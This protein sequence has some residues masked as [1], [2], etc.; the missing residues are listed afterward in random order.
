MLGV[1]PV[2]GLTRLRDE[3]SCWDHLEVPYSQNVARSITLLSYVHFARGELKESLRNIE[4]MAGFISRINVEVGGFEN[5]NSSY[6]GDYHKAI[7]LLQ[8]CIAGKEWICNHRKR[9]K[10]WSPKAMVG[11]C[12]RVR[13]GVSLEFDRE[14]IGLLGKG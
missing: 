8:L 10:Y 11:L 9:E 5:V 2:Y 1:D 12:P 3:V 4:W 13:K 14:F 7:G 6:A